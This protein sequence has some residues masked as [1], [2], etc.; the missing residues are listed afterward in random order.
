VEW[1][2]PIKAALEGPLPGPKAQD[3]MLPAFRLAMEDVPLDGR[4]WRPAAVLLLVYPDARGDL[5]FPIVERSPHVG[6]HRGEMGLPG[7]SL[8][9]GED[10]LHAAIRETEEELSLGG[11][12]AAAIG[13]LG[14]LTPLRVAP[15]GFEVFPHVGCLRSR[16]DMEALAG[17]IE[18]IIE[19]RLDRLLETDCLREEER[20]FDG[21]PWKVPYFDLDGRKVWGATAMILSEFVEVLRGLTRVA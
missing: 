16:P 18:A 8:E 21:R 12:A 4:P 6:H 7:G 2:D 19:V 15:S 17:E 20:P 3:R 11:E 10:S 1:F 13:I 9:A 5:L 14:S